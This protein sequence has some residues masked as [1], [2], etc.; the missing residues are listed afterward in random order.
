MGQ[1]KTTFNK[2]Y[3]ARKKAFNKISFLTKEGEMIHEEMLQG[4]I[5]NSIS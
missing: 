2:N 1:E 3:L 4:G 5:S